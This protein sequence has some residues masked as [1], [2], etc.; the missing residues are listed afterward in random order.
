MNRSSSVHF[1]LFIDGTVSQIPL[2]TKRADGQCC[3]QR[4][5]DAASEARVCWTN[6]QCFYAACSTRLP[7]TQK[8]PSHQPRSTHIIFFVVNTITIQSLGSVGMVQ[9]STLWCTWFECFL[10]PIH[11]FLARSTVKQS[12]SNAVI[13]TSNGATSVQCSVPTPAI[14]DWDHIQRRLGW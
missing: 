6:V 3:I 13:I 8:P 2:W 12:G 7:F 5:G 11:E 9:G 10:G 1:C 14:F 4:H